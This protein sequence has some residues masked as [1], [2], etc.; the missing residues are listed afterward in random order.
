[1]TPLT[2]FINISK[3]GSFVQ[4]SYPKKLT[5]PSTET[6]GHLR[7]FQGKY[8]RTI[9]SLSLLLGHVPGSFNIFSVD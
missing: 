7:T 5:Y 3:A 1:M 2:D 8:V 9:I 6:L 4:F